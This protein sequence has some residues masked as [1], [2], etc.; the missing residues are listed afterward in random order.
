MSTKLVD[1]AYDIIEMQ[2]RITRLEMENEQLRWFKEEF[3][4][5]L[6]SSEQQHDTMMGNLLQ[7]CITPGVIEACQKNNTFSD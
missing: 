2:E 6:K 1:F 3:H 7:L 4:N 5:L